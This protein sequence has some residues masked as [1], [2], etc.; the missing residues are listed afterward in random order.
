ME[1]TSSLQG[2]TGT[3]SI[4]AATPLSEFRTGCADFIRIRFI[5]GCPETYGKE[6]FLTM[7]RC[8]GASAMSMASHSYH[9]L[10][11]RCR[12]CRMH[13]ALYC[14]KAILKTLCTAILV[15]R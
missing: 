14:T 6:S 8:P 10:N 9:L 11:G 15:R 1:E 3:E 4:C 13:F 5:Q 7:S 2:T 12:F